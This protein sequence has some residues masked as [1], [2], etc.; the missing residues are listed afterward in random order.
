MPM[1]SDAQRYAFAV[2]CHNEVANIGALLKILSSVTFQGAHAEKIV[3][4][5]DASIDGTDDVV[6]EAAR[7]SLVPIQLITR[8]RLLG[9]CSAINR[10][11]QELPHVDIIVLVSADVI[12]ADDCIAKLLATFRD[13]GLGVAGGRPL[14]SGDDSFWAVRVTKILWSVHHVIASDCPKTTEITAFRNVGFVLNEASL[15]DE[16]EIEHAIVARGFRV[17]YVAEAL[18]HTP[19]PL[20]IRDY[21][22]QRIR[23]TRGHIL[24]RHRSGFAIS[25]LSIRTRVKAVLRVVRADSS[26]WLALAL[27][28]ILEMAIYLAANVQTYTRPVRSGAWEPIKSTKRVV[29]KAPPGGPLNLT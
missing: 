20:T 3:V 11:L 23:V 9:K 12:P 7:T 26:D 6:S 28:V 1:T 17:A 29:E 15:V 24:L 8:S 5:S 13:P 4:V 19:S 21:M 25:S 14:P 22:K 2:P 27:G 16:A 18:V 10:C